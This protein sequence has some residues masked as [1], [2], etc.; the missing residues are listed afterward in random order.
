MMAFT[1]TNMVRQSLRALIFAAYLLPVAAFAAGDDDLIALLRRQTDLGSDAGQRGDQATVDSFL[2]DQVIFSG[3]DGTVSHESKFDKSDAVAKLLERQTQVFLEAG[4]RG[5]LAEMRRYLDDQLLF[6]NED[7][8]A[9]GRRDFAGGAPAAPPQGVSSS[10]SVSDWVL[11]HQDGVAVSSFVADQLVRYDGQTLD[12]KFLSVETWIK[13]GTAWKLIGSETI[14]LHQDPPAIALSQDA[15]RGYAGTYSAG[16]GSSVV[17]SVDEGAIV[18]ATNGAKGAALRPE[19]RDVFFKSGLPPGYASPRIIFQ[20]NANGLVSGYLNRGLIYS[21]SEPA[22]A[23]ASA[24]P[25]SAA[26]ASAAPATPP[27]GPLK[28][29]DF[30]VHHSGNVAV[31]AFFHDR[32]T[33]YYGQVLQQTYRSMETWIKHGTAWKMIASQGRAMQR[34]PPAVVLPANQLNEYL[35]K[36][37]VGKHFAVITRKGNA[38]AMSTN[39]GKSFPMQAAVRDVFFTPGAPRTCTIFQR[40]ASGRVTGYVSRREERDLKFTKEDGPPRPG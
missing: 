12:Y 13:R 21:K 1:K 35:G 6:I 15:L 37:V 26:P 31:A 39:S 2:D 28:L 32:D 8:V 22:A 11:H 36:Y 16:L 4:Q 25:A 27:L 14:P 19:F 17:V 33:P 34:D 40:D 30:V 24:A 38:L 29:R 3:G 7:G 20:R 23:P 10:I 9:F 5:D 18:L